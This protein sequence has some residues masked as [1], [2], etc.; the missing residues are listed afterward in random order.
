MRNIFLLALSITLFFSCNRDSEETDV[1]EEGYFSITAPQHTDSS[2][3]L[4]VQYFT[5]SPAHGHIIECTGGTII[6]LPDHCIVD[7]NGH[8][9]TGEVQIGVQEALSVPDMLL[10][11]LSTQSGDQLLMSDGMIHLSI[12]ANGKKAKFDP[13]KPIHIEIPTPSPIPGM[14]AYKGEVSENNR[15]NWVDPKPLDR[16]LLHV[17]LAL[18][19]FYPAGFREAVASGMPYK[20]HEKADELITDSLFYAMSVYQPGDLINGFYST[21][22][23]EPLMRGS[24]EIENGKYTKKAF[25]SESDSTEYMP[26]QYGIDPALIKVLRSEAYENTF[27]ATREFELRLQDIYKTCS[28]EVLQLYADNTNMDLYR[29]DSMAAAYLQGYSKQATFLDYA[30]LKCTN[31]QDA[32]PTS[33]HLQD[34]FRKRLQEI[35]EELDAERNKL[36]AAL[37]EKNDAFEKT[38]NNYI[39]LLA[40]R[41]S[42]KMRRYGLNWSDTGWVNIDKPIVTGCPGIREADDLTCVI[43]NS[44]AFDRAYVYIVFPGI[45]SISRYNSDDDHTFYPGNRVAN[46][47]LLPCTQPYAFVAIGYAGNT[48]AF[49]SMWFD[50]GAAPYGNMLLEKTDEAGLRMRLKEFDFKKEYNS[51]SVDLAYMKKMYDEKLRQEK[52]RDEGKFLDALF[53]IVHPCFREG[54]DNRN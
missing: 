18:L 35:K 54:Y 45:K 30:A 34:Y 15:I 28:E 21:A 23:N 20:G 7:E 46:S 32:P 5:F 53:Y 43:D 11:G 6:D 49:Q 25:G 27:I 3:T 33:T 14:M 10:A 24:K 52:L 17:D 44:E 9:I 41:E 12:S 29:V 16:Y 13:A 42:Y 26:S 4:P 36:L 50:P 51:I 47:I 19:D 8:M 40:K 1:P 2:G 31:V 22:Y 48:P 37:Q 39:A 38:A